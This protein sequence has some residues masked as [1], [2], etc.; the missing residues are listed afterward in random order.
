MQITLVQRPADLVPGQL[1]GK[2]VAVIDQLRATTSIA[3]ALSGGADGVHVFADIDEARNAAPKL[4]AL[5][6]GERHS[7]KIE[8]FDLGNSPGELA[9]SSVVGGRTLCMT[10]TNGTTAIVAA[11]EADFVCTL[12]LVNLTATCNHLATLGRDVVFLSS[13]TDGEPTREDDYTGLV[14]AMKLRVPDWQLVEQRTRDVLWNS[15][16]ARRLHSHGHDADIE[17]AM[18]VDSLPI[19][20]RVIDAVVR[21]LD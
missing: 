17:Y 21:K 4:N 7:V 14:A 2:A 20:T 11:G 15:Q 12:S 3:A 9:D 10:T 6:S 18:R 1:K 19:V 16:G 8:G 13:G 5:L